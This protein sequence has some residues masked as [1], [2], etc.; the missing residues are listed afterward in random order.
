M[1][2]I[3]NDP[4]LESVIS[5]FSLVPSDGGR[6]EFSVDGSLLYSKLETGRHVEENELKNLLKT[7]LAGG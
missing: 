2:E 4:E 3:M 1:A 5:S 6:F 7:H